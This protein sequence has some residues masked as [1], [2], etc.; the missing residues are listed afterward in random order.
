LKQE[1]L[2]T[3]ILGIK[4]DPGLPSHQRGQEHKVNRGWAQ[5]LGVLQLAEDPLMFLKAFT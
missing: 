1:F 3:K 5:L 2:G 4:I